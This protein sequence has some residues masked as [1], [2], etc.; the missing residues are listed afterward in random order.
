M[1][2]LPKLT[3]ALLVSAVVVATTTA[4]A[5]TTLL[6]IEASPLNKRLPI[7]AKQHLEACAPAG[8]GKSYRWRFTADQALDFNVHFHATVKSSEGARKEVVE[9]P[10]KLDAIRHHEGNVT[11]QNAYVH[12]WMW[13]N[14]SNAPIQ[15]AF[16]IEPL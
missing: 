6:R 12:C 10:V 13:T 14:R 5:S 9:Y 2:S 1:P 8:K 3:R 7:A 11:T 4:Q 16:T 15:L